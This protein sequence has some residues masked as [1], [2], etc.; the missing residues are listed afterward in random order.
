M[1]VTVIIVGIKSY[2]CKCKCHLIAIII[3]SLGRGV[4]G[5]VTLDEKVILDGYP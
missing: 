4:K 5:Q 3:L 2:F 1:V